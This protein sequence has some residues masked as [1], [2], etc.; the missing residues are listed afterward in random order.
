MTSD[1]P[2]R[3]DIWLDVACLFKTRSQAQAACR[4]GQVEVNGDHGKPHRK[5]RPGDRIIIRRPGG[6]RRIVE[7]I[8]L[9]SNN[10]SKARARELY[11]D[12]TPPPTAEE[13]ELR[14]MQ[15]LSAPPPRPRGAGAPKKR[16]RRELRRLKEDLE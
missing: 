11:E 4:R 13:V 14:K 6:S 16:E 5:V 3:L 15:R 7:V 12:H 2:V 1:D 9:E 10:V 8:E